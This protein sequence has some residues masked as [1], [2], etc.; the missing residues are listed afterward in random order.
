MNEQEQKTILLVEDEALIA[1]MEKETLKRHGFNV[2]TASSGEKAIDITRTTPD[3]DLILMDINLGRGKMDGT[4]A[5]ETILKERDIPVLF[6][7]SYTQPEIVEKTEKITSYGYVTKDSGETVLITSIKM[8]FKLHDAHQKLKESEERFRTIFECTSDPI[9]VW[10]RDY[11]YL[12]ANQ[13]SIDHVGTTAD[14]V[15]GKN[16]RDGLGH[17]PDFMRLWMSRVDHV[18]ESKEVMRVED[19]MLVGENYEYSESVLSPVNDGQGNIMAVGV[20]YHNITER[21]QAEVVLKESETK[22]RRLFE[23]SVDPILMLDGERFVDCNEAAVKIMHCTGKDQLVGTRPSDISPER[24]PDGRLSSEKT[25]ELIG[26]TLKQGSNHFEWKHRTFDGEEFWADVS[27][28]V[29]TIQG[30]QIMYV[31]WRD[32]TERI[33]AQQKIIESEQSLHGI[34][35]SSPNGIGKVRDRV[36]E[37]VNDA[38]CRITGYAFDELKGASTRIL[39]ESD[40]EYERTGEALYREGRVYS[41][42]VTKDGA[43]RDVLIQLSPTTSYSYIFTFTDI[44]DR[45]QSEKEREALERRL[46]QIID[47]LPDPTLAIDSEKR[48]IV[49]NR[50]MENLTGIPAADMMG[51]GDYAYTIPFY[52]VARPQTMDL[53]WVP[54]HEVVEKYPHITKEDDN[55]VIEA[56]CPALFNG[57]GAHI[58][59][60]AAPLKDGDGHLVGAIE[61]IRDMTMYKQAELAIQES[62]ETFRA[63]VENSFDVI[64]TLSKE[65]AFVFLSPAWERHFGYPVSDAIGKRFAPFVHPDDVVPCVEYLTRVLNTGQSETSPPFRVKHANG[66]WK[67]FVANGTPHVDTKGELLF[68]GVGRDIT[69]QRQIE[70]EL[71]ESEEKYRS[72]FENAIEGIFQTTPEGQFL[73]A[74]S[75]L[76]EIFGYDSPEELKSS[77]ADI[78]NQL[79]VDQGKRLEH[80]RILNEKGSVKNY[81]TEMYRKDGSIFWVSVNTRVVGDQAGKPLWYEGFIVDI[82]ARKQTEEVLAFLVQSSGVKSGEGFFELLA[83]YLAKSLGMDFVCIDYL[84]GDGLTA[85]TVAVWCD[86]KFED[87]VTYALKDTPCGEVVGKTVCC[88]PASVCKFFPRDEVLVELRAESY[89]GVTLWS[90]TGKPIGLIAVIGRRPLVNRESVETILKMVAVRAAGEME[91]LKSEDKIKTLLSEKELLLREVHHRIKNNMSVIVSLLSLQADTLHDPS[92]VAAL[93]DAGSRV[94]SMMVLYDK[95]YRSTDFREVSAKAYLTSLIDEIVINFPNH[96]PVTIETQIDDIILDAKILSPVG[97]ILNELLTNAMKHAFTGEESSEFRVRSRQDNR[98]I[99]ELRIREDLAVLPDF[100]LETLNSELRAFAKQV[101]LTVSDNGIGIPESIDIAAHAGFGMQLV[102]ILTEQLGGTIRI[103]REKG[104]KFILE[105]EKQ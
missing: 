103:E 78:G 97:I 52:G 84:E 72:I 43:I 89:V 101:T 19:A 87:N 24:Q 80:L 14:K 49:W 67:L 76:T 51:K 58:W 102:S 95:L 55:Y 56:F 54:D 9:I 98:I 88:F 71:K 28:T 37:W 48:I 11:N 100:S 85:R 4:E 12:Y 59:A 50:A 15:I 75:A 27:L 70:D 13:T 65:G 47:F 92:A 104:T 38:M 64:F 60:K 62:E 26:V 6:L 83:S 46:S 63:H 8:A 93:E 25:E 73:S 79:Y 1:V 21:K 82:T 16:I 68:I 42:F 99:I 29:I 77:I 81:E 35:S 10:D 31:V 94:R 61:V 53:F 23:K 45:V 32:I 86:G 90:H 3:I 20:V 33:N 2:I 57:K 105:F 39:Y 34:L 30:R 7:S 96:K 44:T 41:T 18:F 22:F 17:I 74:N 69:A 66:G 91:Q 40:E 5:A 36:F